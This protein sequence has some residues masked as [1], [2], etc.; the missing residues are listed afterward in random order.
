MQ[1]SSEVYETTGKQLQA[2]LHIVVAQLSLPGIPTAQR[3]RPRS[4]KIDNE[5]G[6][7]IMRSHSCINQRRTSVE[8]PKSSS[9]GPKERKTSRSKST[10]SEFRH[11][12]GNWDRQYHEMIQ[13]ECKDSSMKQNPKHTLRRIKTF[14]SKTRTYE[15]NDKRR[16]SDFE[17]SIY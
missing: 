6:G 15:V 11:K 4:S 17:K 9:S 10:A 5:E 13:N 3:R 7:R 1:A 16:A 8:T 2:L 12:F 14:M